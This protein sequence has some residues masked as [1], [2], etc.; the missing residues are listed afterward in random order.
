MARRDRIVRTVMKT[1]MMRSRLVPA[2]L[3]GIAL[4]MTG[5]GG[6]G[7]RD[8]AA[9]GKRTVSIYTMQLK[10]MFTSYMER[11]FSEF[12]RANPGVAVKWIDQP[13]QEYET[14]LLSMGL[15]GDTPDVMNL[16]YEMILHLR[17]KGLV[18]NIADRVSSATRA[19]YLEPVIREGCTLGGELVALPWYL[20]STIT[21]Y[22]KAILTAA[23]LDPAKPPRNNAELFA[24]ARQVKA[25]TG[26]FGFIVNFTEDGMLKT[27]LAG[28]GIPLVDPSGKK[29]AFNTPEAAALLGEYKKLYDGGVIPR[30]S[31]TAEHR[32]A[33][34]YYKRGKTAFMMTGPQF[35]HFIRNEAPDIYRNT[36][37]GYAFPVGKT[38]DYIVD[39][40][41]LSIS[42][43]SKVP[44]EALDLALWVT[45]G[46]NQY[47]FAKVVTI[48]PSVKETLERPEFVSL[49]KDPVEQEA[50]RIVVKQLQTATVVVPDLPR[51]ADLNK[52]MNEAIIR[53]LTQN[54]PPDQALKDAERRWNEFLAR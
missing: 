47:E 8:P 39:I 29:A 15:S 40:Q 24:M 30:E 16:P 28:E 6:R 25:K 48:F 11:V 21:I 9:G 43:R 4:L 46:K 50:R 17:E 20:S 37:V 13:A 35:L 52:A 5:C 23:G 38:G 10:P 7:P 3:V 54:M 49:G 41:A 18:A 2:M 26:A 1:A 31:A 27:I 32:T 14:K 19:Q 33:I 51:M 22:N 53:V 44:R 42:S 12:E 45:N 34:D 36:G